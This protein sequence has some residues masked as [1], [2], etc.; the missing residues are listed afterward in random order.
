MSNLIAAAREQV[1][2]LTRQAYEKAAQK[3]LLP[4]G[5]DIRGSVDIPKDPSLGDYASSFAL[6]GAKALGQNPRTL[7]QIL[8]DH[9][10]LGGSYFDRVEI[11]GPGFLNFRLG[12]S[13]LGEVLSAI[14]REGSAYGEVDEGKG[15]KVMVEFV[16]ANPTGPMHMGNA[17][18]GV[19]G[20][21]LANLLTHA[22][23]DARKEFYVNDA[24]NQ[25]HKFATSIHARYMQL[26]LGEE[27]YPFPEEGYHG[28]D[29]RQLAQS[30][31]ALHGDSYRDAPEE[32]WLGDMSRFGLE[33]NI[34]NM[35]ADLKR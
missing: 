6:A 15:S 4:H 32:K 10:E 27:N 1:T 30:F 19:L 3:G 31:Y 24:G 17:R 18:G 21:T 14:E 29:I 11:A 26:L 33:V 12:A 35:E 20:D 9:M 25:I 8:V 16:S 13:W 23:Y 22:G 5:G 34:P 28:E 2:L 7:A